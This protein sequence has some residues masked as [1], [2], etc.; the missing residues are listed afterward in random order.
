VVVFFLLMYLGARFE[1]KRS[2]VIVGRIYPLVDI[3]AGSIS[4]I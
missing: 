1:S 4:L 2:V 3:E